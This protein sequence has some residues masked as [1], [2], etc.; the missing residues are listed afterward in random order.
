MKILQI[1]KAGVIYFALV[2]GAGF[3][4]GTARTL[5]VT[6]RLGERYAELIETPFMLVVTILAA[7]WIN[8]R[9]ELPGSFA[10]R[11]GAGLTAL[12]LLLGT[13]VTVVLRLR[14]LTLDQY[15]A[16]RDPVAGTAYLAMLGVF[17]M[18]PLLVA[19]K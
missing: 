9:F 13:E 17:A 19:R 10:T 18:M 6:P 1:L 3:V 4:F 8:R 15:L 12:A 11:I 5:W 7:R 2:F 14:G 16:G